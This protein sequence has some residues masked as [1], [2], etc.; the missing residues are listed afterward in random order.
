MLICVIHYTYF[1]LF[2]FLNTT[3]NLTSKLRAAIQNLFMNIERLE[4]QIKMLK[5]RKAARACMNQIWCHFEQQFTKTQWKSLR[6]FNFR[7]AQ[8]MSGDWFPNVPSTTVTDLHSAGSET[9]GRG[10]ARPH[11]PDVAS[12]AEMPSGWRRRVHL[13]TKAASFKQRWEATDDTWVAQCSALEIQVAKDA[14]EIQS[15][16]IFLM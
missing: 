11:G 14:Q 2:C 1:L 5:N 12:E 6:Q 15:F 10:S 3:G 9:W 7:I 13:E 4:P 16:P 8:G